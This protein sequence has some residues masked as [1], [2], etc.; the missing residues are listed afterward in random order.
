MAAAEKHKVGDSIKVAEGT[1][2]V[3]PD[4]SEHTIVGGLYVLD[5]AGTHDVGG[6][7]VEVG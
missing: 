6:E 2:V 4:G 3:R 7:A 1:K 5:V